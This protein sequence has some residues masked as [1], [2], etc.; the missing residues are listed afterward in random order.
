MTVAN[1][2]LVIEEAGNGVKV[3]FDFAFKIFASSDLTV[4]KKSAAGVYTDPLVENTDYTVEFDTEAETGTVTYIVAPVGAGGGSYIKRDSGFTQ[5]SAFPREG[6]T[7]ARTLENALDR[8]VLEVQELKERL[9]RAAVQLA[10]PSV[11][12]QVIIDAPEDGQALNYSLDDDGIFHIIPADT[13]SADLTAAADAAVAAAASAVSAAAAAV[14]AAALLSGSSGLY[15]A[16]P[17]APSSV[18]YYVSTDRENMIELWVPAA[19]KWVL[20]G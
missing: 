19:A 12:G 14:A 17:A 11:P 1:T 16:R 13:D 20:I 5:E 4:R 10:Y 9:D 18:T 15:S 3:A 6:V 7:P 8:L 2:D